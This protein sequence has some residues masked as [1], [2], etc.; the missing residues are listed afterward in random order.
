MAV[1]RGVARIQSFHLNGPS[2]DLQMTGNVPLRTQARGDAL[3][4]KLGGK[5]NLAVLQQFRFR[6]CAFSSGALADA[7]VGGTLNKPLVSGK[8]DLQKASVNYA[9]WPNGITNANGTIQFSGN[10]AVLRNVTGES[11]RRGKI[12]LNGFA[13]QSRSLFVSACAPPHRKCAC[14]FNKG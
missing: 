12:T 3:S 9:A 2:T 11:G 4:L 7:A 10:S 14:E 1:D 8:L 13:N 6:R 5:V